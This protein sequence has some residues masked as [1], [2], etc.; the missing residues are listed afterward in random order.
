MYLEISKA[1]GQLCMALLNMSEPSLLIE[2][3]ADL[4][5]DKKVEGVSEIRDETDRESSATIDDLRKFG[6]LTFRD[7]LEDWSEA[8]QSFIQQ[9]FIRADEGRYSLTEIGKKYVERVVTIEF[10]EK[11]NLRKIQS[12][13]DGSADFILDW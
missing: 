1:E 11:M 2:L 10:N 4:V 3:I 9:D 12:L 7:K 8:L 5:N 6:E 13:R